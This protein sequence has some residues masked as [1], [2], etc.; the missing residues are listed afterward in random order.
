VVNEVH[1]PIV[2][3]R[4]YFIAGKFDQFQRHIPYAALIQAFGSLI[5]QLLT[6]S[7]Q[8]LALWEEKLLGALGDNG[9]VIIDVIPE[10]E[11]I[12]GEMPEL[13]QLGSFESQNRFNRV[14]Q[15]FVSV[16]AQAEHPLVLFLDDLQWADSASLEL[17]RTLTS[18]RE[19]Q[20]LLLVGAYRDNEVDPTHRLIQT[21]DKIRESGTV[22]NEIVIQPLKM[23][24]VRQLVAETLG[25]DYSSTTPLLV[26]DDFRRDRFADRASENHTEILADLIYQKTQGNP[27]F[28]TQ[29]LKTLYAENLLIYDFNTDRWQWNIEEI[30]AVGI[31]D[32]GVVDLVA[33]NI[34]KLPNATQ[35]VLKLA[36]CLGNQFNLEMLAIVNEESTANTALQLWDA[37]STGLI[38]PLSNTYKIPLL[39]EE[40]AAAHQ[41]S[42]AYKFL[43]DRVQQAAYFLI[44]ENDKK[45]IHLKIGQLLLKNTTP[46]Q[47]KENI[48]ALVNQLNFATDLLATQSEKNRLAEL[49]LIAAQKAKVA[50]AYSSTLTYVNVGLELLATDSWIHN[51]DLTMDLYVAAI[52]A[53][54]VNSHFTR[55][56]VLAE[57]A[58][59]Q[60]KTLLKTVQI[61]E[62]Q[63]QSYIAQN[64]MQL[65]IETGLETLKLLRIS[66][67]Q[68]PPQMLVIEDLANLPNMTDPYKLRAIRIFINLFAPALISQ[69]N[70]LLPICFTMLDL[71][72][73]Y[74][75]PPSASY[76]YTYY[77]LLLCGMLGDIEVGYRF[78]Q[79][80]INLLDRL[81]AKEYKGKVLGLFNGFIRFWKEPLRSTID[82][83]LESIQSGLEIGD[84]EH[85]CYSILNYCSYQFFMG[86]NLTIVG[87]RYQQYLSL[88]ER[89]QQQYS[90]VY[91]NF[92]QKLLLSLTRNSQDEDD[93]LDEKNEEKIILSLKESNNYTSIFFFYL[94]KL[95]VHYLLKRTDLAIASG[96]KAEDYQQS[97][98][99]L[100]TVA[101]Y[102]FYYSLALLA[103]YPKAETSQQSQL[104]DCVSLNQEKMK[105]WAEHAPSNFQHKYQLVEA[106]KARVIGNN[107]EAINLYDQAI[108]GAKQQG[109]IQEEALAN[110]LA[111]EFYLSRGKEKI[112]QIYLSDAY[113]G[114]LHWG[115]ITK[116]KDL[117]SR[118][119]QI[120]SSIKAKENT[121]LEI[122]PQQ[123]STLTVN[124]DTLDLYAIIK[125][126]QRISQEILLDKLTDK[127]IKILLENAGAQT[128]FLILSKEGKLVIEVAGSLSPKE[129]ILRQSIPLEVSKKLPK[130]VINYVARTKESVILNDAANEVAFDS[131]PYIQ[132]YQP[133]SILC[134]PIL[135]QGKQIGIVYLENNLVNNA[136]SRDRQEIV[137]LICA[138]A[139]I[140]LENAKLYFDLQQS[141][142]RERAE[143]QFRKALAKEK[144]LTD[145]KSRFISMASHEFRTPL[146]TILS[147]TEL[148]KYYSQNWSEEKKQTYFDRIENSVKQMTGLLEDVLLLGKAEAGKIEFQPS[149]LDLVNFC[150]SL[151]EEIQ[152]GTSAKQTI[153]FSSEPECQEA[154]MD[155]SLLRHILSNLLSNAVKY[156]PPDST[157]L[158]ELSF[159]EKQAIFHIQD[160]GIG[161]PEEDQKRLFESFHRAQNV[162]KIS[163][164]GLGLAIVKRSVDLHG[165]DISVNSQVN[166][167]TTFT[168]SIPWKNSN[169]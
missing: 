87:D 5:R 43:H 77:G 107:W 54:Y 153:V 131:D 6:E 66:L 96:N 80:G 125:A 108:Q 59:K 100:V 141:Q 140:S 38:L 27:F 52:E 56:Q 113:Y 2:A 112:A 15:Q 31:A 134:I 156:S 81:N 117:E 10:V 161:I 1:K 12:V 137:K 72:I 146:T 158:F 150:R 166:V 139:A 123:S 105:K 75:N 83:L 110:E 58:L 97:S 92:C 82:P 73:E 41:V 8:Q 16:F 127:L 151:V 86:E 63:I 57:V 45:A 163:G 144:E 74:G 91:L 118:Y 4:G 50:T 95:I 167:G 119:P 21:L 20:Y 70:L 136:F 138:Q 98:T 124:L 22:V 121:S 40:E 61:N 64:Q 132:K 102:N 155:E 46:E 126:S 115:A 152:L 49:N 28:L 99:G 42:V 67:K 17:I 90:S 103:D 154:Y 88:I 11:L 133:K 135:K 104:L 93:Y 149:Q 44:P 35:Q 143:K 148:L 145:L 160:Q 51:Y 157:I 128:G 142:A 18:D 120:L 48:F 60:A 55:A 37:L 84:I 147:T 47:Q 159:H 33:R 39:F 69:P 25:E 13:P 9:R 3:A 14:F 7:Q 162:G 114:Y 76:V 29:F 24:S 109:Y 23:A 94:A 71:F 19:I 122:S 32:D 89:L 116:V 34:N 65:A 68:E 165:G 168:V 78:G 26:E 129:I 79:L 164:T 130:S 36:A 53:E 85:A 106:E 30:L 111:A 169:Q 62:L 101:E